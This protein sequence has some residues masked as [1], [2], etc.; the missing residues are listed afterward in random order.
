MF[1]Y[2][3]LTIF[4]LLCL[5]FKFWSNI[6]DSCRSY[7]SVTT[8]SIMSIGDR[9]MCWLWRG[10]S[11]RSSADLINQLVLEILWMW[12]GHSGQRFFV[13]ISCRNNVSLQSGKMNL[14]DWRL[15]QGFKLRWWLWPGLPKTHEGEARTCYYS[16]S[17]NAY[18]NGCTVNVPEDSFGPDTCA[19]GVRPELATCKF[20]GESKHQTLSLSGWVWWYR[21]VPTKP[22][23]PS[24]S[25]FA[26]RTLR[27]Q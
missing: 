25:L 14:H 26:T 15:L 5:S 7:H 6:S 16:S 1:K 20:S 18:E 22:Y 11:T 24:V 8:A 9:E 23:F 19:S 13:L 21:V 10:L 12:N 4:N 2:D 27:S 17:N 3:K